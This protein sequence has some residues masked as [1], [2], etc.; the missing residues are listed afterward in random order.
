MGK[1]KALSSHTSTYQIHVACQVNPMLPLQQQQLTLRLPGAW[2]CQPGLVPRD[3]VRWRYP[4]GDALVSGWCGTCASSPANKNPGYG[5]FPPDSVQLR[6][7]L[8]VG[9]LVLLVCSEWLNYP[10]GR[11]WVGLSG[12]P[13]S[14]GSKGAPPCIPVLCA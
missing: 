9:A 8:P 7:T 2:A 3:P 14:P 1:S 4:P 6:S 5:A 11:F 10:I 12:F 13:A